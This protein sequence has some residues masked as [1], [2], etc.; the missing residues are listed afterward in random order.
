MKNVASIVKLS[1]VAFRQ[2]R[3]YGGL[4]VYVLQRRFYGLRGL[5][6]PVKLEDCVRVELRIRL[7]LLLKGTYD[8]AWLFGNAATE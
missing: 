5:S 2:A 3:P 8:I 7:R 4:L 6:Y 1:G